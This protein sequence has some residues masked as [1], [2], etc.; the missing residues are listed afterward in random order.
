MSQ[1][2]HIVLLPGL[3]CDDAIWSPQIEALGARHDVFCPEFLDHDTIEA[4]AVD[5]LARAPGTFALAGHSMGGRVA[6]EIVRRAPQRVERLALLDTGYRPAKPGESEGRGA[7]IKTALEEGMQALARDWLPPMVAAHHTA[8]AALM[9]RLTAMVARAT[10]ALFQRQ[11]NALLT[12]P[13]AEPVLT[14]IWQP[15]ALIVGRLDRW[16]PLAQHEEMAALIPDTVLTVIE[17]S[18]HMCPAE[19]PAAVSAALIA[20]MARESR[21]RPTERFAVAL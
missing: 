10:P 15:T 9:G 19:Q 3:L 20:W 6:L 1:G 5:V 14:T 8:D 18:G 4:M 21:Q 2:S 7:H 17:D 16:S 13:D 11:T 12:R